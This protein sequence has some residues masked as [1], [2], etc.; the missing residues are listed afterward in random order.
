VSI[1]LGQLEAVAER[2]GCAVGVGVKRSHS[3]LRL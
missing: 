2:F 3:V 1:A